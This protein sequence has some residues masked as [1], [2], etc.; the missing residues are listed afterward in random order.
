MPDPP[1]GIVSL[2]DLKTLITE[3]PYRGGVFLFVHLLT[4]L[5][6]ATKAKLILEIGTGW[7][8]STRAFVHGLNISDGKIISCDSV[9]RFKE[10]NHPRFTFINKT[11]SQLAKTWNKRIDIL[12]IDADHSYNQVKFDYRIFSPFVVKNGLI[13][14]HDTNTP[15]Y[16]GPKKV[17][18]EIKGLPKISSEQ[19]PGITIIQKVK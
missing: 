14:L 8:V 4:G 5:T 1:L 15:L 6:I 10:F 3:K 13:I 18:D 17:A 2:T 16:P 19:Y 7:L 12:F 9:K 11:S